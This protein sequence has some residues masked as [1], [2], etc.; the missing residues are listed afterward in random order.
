MPNGNGLTI[1]EREGRIERA[2]KRERVARRQ[3]KMDIADVA[4]GG[5]GL[6]LGATLTRGMDLGPLPIKV[7]SAAGLIGLYLL[8]TDKPTSKPGRRFFTSLLLGMGA[9]R[10]F[11]ISEERLSDIWSKF[12]GG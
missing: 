3:V 8:F 7:N 9:E 11:E 12:T 2:Q 5:V 6:A 1:R 10:V 4:G